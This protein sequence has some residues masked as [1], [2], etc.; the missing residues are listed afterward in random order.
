MNAI[1]RIVRVIFKGEDGLS[2]EAGKA[3]KA[4]AGFSS[5]AS[6]ALKS[7]GALVAGV[8]LGAFFKKAVEEAEASR[9]AMAQLAVTVDNSGASFR[10]MEPDIN[11]TINRLARL[12]AFS[13]DDFVSAMQ[14]MTLKTGDAK[15]ALANLGQAA[16]LA[17]ASGKPL[18]E[19]AAALAKAHEGNTKALFSLVPQI[20][21]ATDW[22]TALAGATKGL[23]KAQADALGPFAAISKQLGEVT[24]AVGKAIL[25]NDQLSSTGNLLA[26]ALADLAA[27]IE[28][29]GTA[30]T[31]MLS[32]SLRVGETFAGI[33]A[34]SFRYVAAAVFGLT[35][36]VDEL[37]FAI[38][39]LARRAEWM[40]GVVLASFGKLVE[41]GGSL[42]KIFGITVGE[43]MGRKLREA[44]EGMVVT[45]DEM[46]KLLQF[47]LAMHRDKTK[48]TWTALWAEAKTATDTGGTALAGATRTA[49][50]KS[51]TEVDTASAA[52][53]K[54]IDAKLGGSLKL[55]VKATEEAI[56]SLSETANKSLPP[57]TAE[58]FKTHMEGIAAH[59]KDVEARIFGT[60]KPLEDSKEST[61]Q[62]WSS[63]EGVARGAL[64]AATAFGVIDQ[65][66]ANTLNSVLNIATSI[67]RIY[68]GDYVGGVTGLVGGLANLVSSLKD[69]ENRRLVTEN[70]Q[71]LK[72]LRD[73]MSSLDLGVSGDD[74]LQAKGG[75]QDVMAVLRDKRYTG[76]SGEIQRARDIARAMSENGLTAGDINRIADELGIQI[77]DKDGNWSV[78]RLEQLLQAIEETNFASV[79]GD[80]NAQLEWFRQRQR[81]DGTAGTGTG[82]QQMLEFLSTTGGVS[83]LRG[84]DLSNL[85]GSRADL[86][87]LF[88]AIGKGGVGPE[89][90]GA[91]T[92]DDFRDIL[93]EIIGNIDELA[94]GG[95]SVGVDLG[96]GTEIINTIGDGTNPDDAIV[97]PGTGMPVVT[98]S[99]ADVVGA[100]T[101]QTDIASGY[102]KQSLEYQ[103]RTADN[104]GRT[105]DQLATSLEILAEIAA[106]TFNPE[107]ARGRAMQEAARLYG[108]SRL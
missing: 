44:G 26:D 54:S 76:M 53:Q 98:F 100:I 34:P 75:L 96:Q 78:D 93:I 89:F 14:Q 71:Q 25:G 105:A 28:A 35:N 59:A 83:A 70:T 38:Q 42:L 106:N 11:A 9:V 61:R 31:G 82:L 74:F 2:P 73:E 63:M 94:Q 68:A 39:I 65:K 23:A 17:A 107:S 10:A 51:A 4:I 7:L 6:G 92:G 97:G 77:K 62:M 57:E 84:I 40:V 50:G 80:F 15:W 52:I 64:D 108:S 36:G 67:G 46:F 32:V 1:E 88:D 49:L 58:K 41:R 19:S 3:E 45:S 72:R 81:L 24:E 87:A 102:W 85:S 16:D 47:D 18:E 21:G 12:T 55:V 69:P 90:L 103:G 37:W 29:N 60:A 8:A 79:G 22:Q 33:V 27:W 99:L 56:E 101:S 66:S 48:A 86:M 20:K 30:L 104:T 13:D 43:D 5:T 95:N 91:L